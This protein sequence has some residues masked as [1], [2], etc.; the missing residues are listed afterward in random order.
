MTDLQFYLPEYS[1]DTTVGGSVTSTV[2][3]IMSDDITA[4]YHGQ[5]T[6]WVYNKYFL[7]LTGGGTVSDVK[8]YLNAS[9]N[10]EQTMFATTA[11]ADDCYSGVRAVY[12][13]QSN[14]IFYENGLETQ[15]PDFVH[16]HGEPE[17]LLL[18]NSSGELGGNITATAGTGNAVP[19]WVARKLDEHIP[20]GNTHFS[21]EVI[22]SS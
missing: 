14:V 7:N 1:G 6:T 15:R 21:I 2:G 17:A 16:A 22:Y 8:L 13:D 18:Y 4:P 19:V 10:P 9:T 11:Y 3:E 20:S 5:G 12:G